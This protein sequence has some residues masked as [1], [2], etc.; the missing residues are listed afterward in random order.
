[1][2]GRR[3]P[4]EGP[5][6]TTEDPRREETTAEMLAA[7]EINPGAIPGCRDRPHLPDLTLP[8]GELVHFS[9]LLLFES[10]EIDHG[11][12]TV[13]GDEGDGNSPTVE[14]LLGVQMSGSLCVSHVLLPQVPAFSRFLTG[15]LRQPLILTPC[16]CRQS[17]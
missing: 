12:A 3:R 6:W 10:V 15:C 1:M 14:A 8:T 13:G 9:G 5:A 16:V 7:G 11:V 4:E 2:I 17:R